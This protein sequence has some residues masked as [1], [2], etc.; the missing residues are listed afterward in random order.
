MSYVLLRVSLSERSTKMGIGMSHTHTCLAST[1]VVVL[2]QR[3]VVV[4][5]SE[6]H[7]T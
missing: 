4:V 7:Y 2:A 3:K 6:G 1:R 5:V